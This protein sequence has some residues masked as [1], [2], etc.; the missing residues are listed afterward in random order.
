VCGEL[1]Q[2]KTA[3][4]S[5]L[6]A[7][8]VVARTVPQLFAEIIEFCRGRFETVRY[9]YQISTSVAQVAALPKFSGPKDEPQFLNEV[10]GRK[11]L[12]VTFGT[13]LTHPNLNPRILGVFQ[14]HA[15]LCEES[16]DRRFT[17]HLSL[18]AKG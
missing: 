2:V 7:L 14:R 1:L 4:T 6:E 18:L 8:C 3:G 10:A 5:F 15:A 16:P 9:S 11:L 13:A 17:K 12:H